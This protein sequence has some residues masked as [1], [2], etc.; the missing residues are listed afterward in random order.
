MSQSGLSTNHETGRIPL[1]V[2]HMI[3]HQRIILKVS[4]LCRLSLLI[5]RSLWLSFLA[6][7][8]SVSLL[9]PPLCLALLQP[10]SS[11]SCE[12]CSFNSS[13][14]D[15]LFGLSGFT[16]VTIPC[17]PKWCC[18]QESRMDRKIKEQLVRKSQKRKPKLG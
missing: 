10:S 13:E 1:K 14:I 12:V 8:L 4:Q 5:A 17:V 6:N 9:T 7:L 3:A 2:M 15:P 16:T 11:L 18:F